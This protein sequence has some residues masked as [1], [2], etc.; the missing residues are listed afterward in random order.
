MLL[1]KFIN[2][3]FV[4]IVQLSGIVLE[5]TGAKKNS[6]LNA[7][8]IERHFS[9]HLSKLIL[10]ILSLYDKTQHHSNESVKG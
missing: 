5:M 9:L 2:I 8:M 7:L 10:S 3:K 1:I 6:L 4:S